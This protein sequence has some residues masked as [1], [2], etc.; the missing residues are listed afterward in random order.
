MEIHLLLL[1]AGFAGL[2]SMNVS[3]NAVTVKHDILP[4]AD[5]TT[6]IIASGRWIFHTSQP[7]RGAFKV[8]EKSWLSE[9]AYNALI[10]LQGNLHVLSN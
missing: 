8:G 7:Y 3:T 4:G 5:I 1:V 10:G 2:H 6:T 9:C